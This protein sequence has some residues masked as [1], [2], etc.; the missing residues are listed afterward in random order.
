LLPTGRAF[1]KSLGK[2]KHLESRRRK[3]GFF[4]LSRK[5][6]IYKFSKMRTNVQFTSER[7]RKFKP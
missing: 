6:N 2:T 1:K 3:K 4:L 5:L 7:Q